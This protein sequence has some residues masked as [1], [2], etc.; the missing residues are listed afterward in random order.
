MHSLIEI[1]FAL[2]RPLIRIFFGLT[3][4]FIELGF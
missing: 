3:Q 1:E 2:R 4:Q